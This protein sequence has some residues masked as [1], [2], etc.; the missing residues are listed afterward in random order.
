[1]TYPEVCSPCIRRTCIVKDM[2]ATPWPTRKHIR[3]QISIKMSIISINDSFMTIY[4]VHD[5]KIVQKWPKI[6]KKKQN[7]AKFF[8]RNSFYHLWHLTVI[9]T[10]IC[11]NETKSPFDL[12]HSKLELPISGIYVFPQNNLEMIA[13]KS[14]QVHVF[15][16][17]VIICLL[18]A[19]NLRKKLN[20]SRWFLS[21]KSFWKY[22][23]GSKKRTF[24]S[25]TCV[26]RYF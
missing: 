14:F 20:T 19:N 7:S 11:I 3:L 10:P 15:S 5:A 22:I 9:N 23:F 6:L 12:S 25:K 16:N 17:S 1:M 4:T 13:S 26:F 8:N 24:W 21:M 2:T 18:L